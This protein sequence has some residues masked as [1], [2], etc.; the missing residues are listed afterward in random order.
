MHRVHVQPFSRFVS[1]IC[2]VCVRPF[3]CCCRS[4]VDEA[5]GN[6]SRSSG[7]FRVVS[8]RFGFQSTASSTCTEQQFR[9]FLILEAR[10]LLALHSSSGSVRCTLSV[11]RGRGPAICSFPVYTHRPRKHR[12]YSTGGGF[13][14]SGSP[15]APCLTPTCESGMHLN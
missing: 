3:I 13:V 14:E 1:R 4:G 15:R 10:A 7:V 11:R 5:A 6:I 2:C 8:C 9:P 12:C